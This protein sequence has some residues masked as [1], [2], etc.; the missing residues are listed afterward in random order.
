MGRGFVTRLLV[1]VGGLGA[2]GGVQGQGSVVRRGG[3]GGAGGL[4]GVQGQ[5]PAYQHSV[6]IFVK[7]PVEWQSLFLECAFMDY[8]QV[9]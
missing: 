9:K 7:F 1:W 6:R 3:G 5:D 8:H 2:S 4:R